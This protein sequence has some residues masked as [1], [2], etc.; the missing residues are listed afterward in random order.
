MKKKANEINGRILF[1]DNITKIIEELNGSLCFEIGRE[2]TTDVAEAVAIMMRNKIK[3][4]IWNMTFK[5]EF[6]NI[7][8]VKSLY[9]LSG[10]DNEWIMLQNYNSNWT[11]CSMIFQEE[12]G[13]EILNIIKKSKTLGDIRNKFMK[14]LNLPVLYEFALSQDLLKLDF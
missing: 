14:H 3:G 4:D 9:W 1:E 6:N 10:G 7:S 12:F 13:L 2:I 5:Y 11:E 8:P